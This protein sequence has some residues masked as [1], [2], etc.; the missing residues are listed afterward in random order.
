M[1]CKDCCEWDEDFNDDSIGTC[2]HEGSP[3]F[4]ATR[5]ADEVG[6]EFGYTVDDL[7]DEECP[8]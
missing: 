3:H 7:F 1:N 6:C 5:C 4:R 8:P 2:H